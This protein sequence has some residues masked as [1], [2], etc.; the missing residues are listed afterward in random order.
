MIKINNYIVW[1]KDLN[2]WL[3]RMNYDAFLLLMY[4]KIK[5]S[6]DL[7]QDHSHVLCYAIIRVLDFF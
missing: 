3:R 1:K 6:W 4:G 7:T 2:S 5:I